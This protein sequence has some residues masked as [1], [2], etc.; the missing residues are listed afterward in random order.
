MRLNQFLARCGVASRRKAE[1][2][3]RAGRVTV[4]G[5]VVQNLSTTIDPERDRVEI[6]GRELR[7]P[8]QFIH[9]ALNKPAG[10][11]VTRSDP[12]SR[13]TIYDLL[14]AEHSKTVGAVGRLDRATTGLLLLTDDG[15]LAFRLTHPR[16]GVEKE[17]L[18][19]GPEEPTPRQIS[20]LMRG[21]ALEDG[22]A[23]ALRAEEAPVK[24]SAS[25]A[26]RIVLASGRKRIVRRMC[27]AV[28]FEL[29]L[30][31]R[32]RVGPIWL[33]DLAPG[34]CRPLNADEISALRKAS[35]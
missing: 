6:E 3:I 29:S 21:V 4:N 24:E 35:N 13:K 23:R 8:A 9:L 11:D 12:H 27:K 5:T 1:E 20:Q 31:H 18:A 19:Y 26:L 32:V 16:H 28:G 34:Q 2:W 33:G 7:P 25:P 22:I 14:P 15:D 10:Y 17:Y 30:L